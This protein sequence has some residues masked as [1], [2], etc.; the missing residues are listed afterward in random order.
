[1]MT[2]GLPTTGKGSDC[3]LLAVTV[4]V[5]AKYDASSDRS[6]APTNYFGEL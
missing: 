5:Q 2:I 1:M 6:L 3:L 4:P